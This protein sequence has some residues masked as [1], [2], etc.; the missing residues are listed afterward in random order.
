MDLPRENV[1]AGAAFSGQQ[2]CRVARR[3]DCSRKSC[4]DCGEQLEAVH[5][6]H[7][8]I[9]KNEIERPLTI[10]QGECVASAFGQRNLMLT[11]PQEAAESV[12]DIFFIVDDEQFCQLDTPRMRQLDHER[13]ALS[14]GI[15]ES[16]YGQHPLNK[17]YA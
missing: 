9:A 12:A 10:H 5:L 1:L 7:S 3:S 13:P 4:F 15:Q 11:G 14:E 2:D 16:S 6:G 8:P 17:A